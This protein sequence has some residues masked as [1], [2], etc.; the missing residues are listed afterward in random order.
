MAA[1]EMAENRERWLQQRRF[2]PG[3]GWCI[4]SSD[5][6]SILG[7]KDAGTPLQIWHEKTG[8]LR[9]PENE[10][11]MW[12]RLHEDTIARYWRDRNRST[13]TAVGLIAHVQEPWQQTTLDRRVNSCPLRE[14][15]ER[16]ALEIKT[17]D[18]FASKNWH[19]TIPDRHLAQMLHQ[20]YVT[21]YSHLHYAL[22]KGGNDYSQGVVRAEAEKDVMAYVLRKVREFRS[23]H[24]AIGLEVAPEWPI[25]E[26]AGSLITLDNL[27]HP[28]RAD[29]RTIEEIEDVI[30]FAKARATANAAAKAYKQAQARMRQ[31]ADGARYVLI[32]TPRGPELAYEFVPRETSRVELSILAERYPEIYADPEIV[33]HKT[34]WQINLPKS[35]QET[36]ED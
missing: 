24:L 25:E 17:A 18:A 13:V 26:R 1:R 31:L 27:V 34:S 21:G 30:A 16:C 3:V 22:L 35:M 2:R 28:E 5:V 9:Q 33:K 23:E 29:T 11:M 10:R 19:K 15:D 8:D 36:P 20:L 12:G 14:G 32:D 7:I 6:P 4:G